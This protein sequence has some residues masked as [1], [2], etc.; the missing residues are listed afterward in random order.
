MLGSTPCTVFE[1][2]S[3]LSSYHVIVHFSYTYWHTF[4]I[5]MNSGVRYQ[6][7]LSTL[8][9]VVRSSRFVPGSLF[10]FRYRYRGN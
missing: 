6:E 7:H 3:G 1:P 10:D 9:S 8:L 5:I 2:S 4:V